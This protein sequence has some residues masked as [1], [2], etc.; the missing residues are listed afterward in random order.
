MAL[1]PAS[2]AKM[3]SLWILGDIYTVKI[4]G[5][6]TQ[7]RYSV[8]EI[9]VAPNK[10]PPLHKHSIE[11]ETFY[12]LE[13]DFLFPYGNDNDTKAGKGQLVYARRGEFHT[14]KNIGSSPGKLMLIISPPQFEKFFEEIGIP[15]EDKSSFQPPEITHDVIQNVVKTAA[16]YSL[17]IK[18]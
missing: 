17:A 12:V 9:E 18:I 16:K 15:I 2:Q 4:S 11:D 5:D 10:G 3:K 14:Y 8:W 13:G 6:Q 7:G 1:L